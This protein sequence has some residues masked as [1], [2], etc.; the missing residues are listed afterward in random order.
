[1]N[2]WPSFC[3]AVNVISIFCRIFKEK[4]L[5]TPSVLGYVFSLKIDR[6]IFMKM[7]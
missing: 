1:M 3:K 4:Y 6:M 2:F 7:F 5:G